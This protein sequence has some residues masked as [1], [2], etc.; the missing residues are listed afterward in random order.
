MIARAARANGHRVFAVAHEDETDPVLADHVDGIIWV[1]IGQLERTV[2][3]FKANGITDA[4]MAG[5]ITKENMFLNFEPDAKAMAV[6]ARVSDLS[7]DNFLRALADEFE[8]DDIFIRPST[9]YVPDLLA[10][11][12]VLTGRRPTAAEEADIEY[13]WRIAKALGRLDVGQCVVVRKR[14]TLALEAIDGSDETIRRGGRLG[15]ENAVVVKVVK[16]NQDLRFDL[17]SVGLQ[18]IEVMA[19]V[20]ASVLAIEADRTLVFNREE[21]IAAADEAGIAVVARPGDGND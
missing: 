3:F 19:E 1:K 21:M 16:P 6:I 8:N 4:L 10:T 18:T 11:E 5:G 20:K 9:L 12:G 13:G 14:A 2:D 17:P 15:Q 7:D